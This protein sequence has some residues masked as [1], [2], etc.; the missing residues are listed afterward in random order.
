MPR[1]RSAATTALD[2]T[3]GVLNDCTAATAHAHAR[4][5]A[6]THAHRRT[7]TRFKPGCC[8]HHHHQIGLWRGHGDARQRGK[9][10][11]EC[12]RVRVVVRD[13]VP[14][15]PQCDDARRREH[16]RLVTREHKRRPRPPPPRTSS[17]HAHTCRMPP[18]SAFLTRR[19]FAMNA[20]VPTKR[21]PTG[22]P[23]PLLRQTLAESADAS[24]RAGATPVAAHALHSRAPV[25]SHACVRACDGGGGRAPL[26]KAAAQRHT[27]A[28]AQAQE[29]FPH[30][31]RGAR[32][33]ARARAR[34]PRPCTPAAARARPR[35]CASAPPPP[36]A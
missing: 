35:G 5:H 6:Q 4:T 15:V 10:R 25:P 27:R 2:V 32:F 21:D 28:D 18:P 19:P 8:T 26:A 33:H 7:H 24:I 3:P 23:R 17:H 20:F 16:A 30:R 34:R 29:P 36:C 9:P 14:H 12:A 22:A 1:G 11:R 13:A 31:P